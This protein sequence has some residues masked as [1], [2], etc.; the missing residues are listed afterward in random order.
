MRDVYS[1]LGSPPAQLSQKS[2]GR[3]SNPQTRKGTD[4]QSVCVTNLHTD[5]KAIT[6]GIEPSPLPYRGSVPIYTI[7]NYR[8][9]RL[10]QVFPLSLAYCI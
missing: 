7:D 6:E 3:D 9:F 2:T 4:L 1:V 10:S 8:L 5:G